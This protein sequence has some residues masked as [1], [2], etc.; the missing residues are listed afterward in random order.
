MIKK[1]ADK[2]RVY[3][4]LVAYVSNE[5]HHDDYNELMDYIEFAKKDVELDA[6]M[7]R[8]WDSQPVT[9]SFTDFES[10]MLYGNI[11]SDKRFQSPVK[12]KLPIYKSWYGIAASI[13]LMTLLGGMLFLYGDPSKVESFFSRNEV[14]YDIKPGTNKAIL[15]LADGTEVV[16][17]DVKD[18]SLAK[19]TGSNIIQASG[20]QLVYENTSKVAGK[21]MYN[22][23]ETP[24]GGQYQVI[25]PDG[26]KVWLNAASKLKYPVAFAG[27]EKRIVELSGEAYFEVAHNRKQPFIVK[28][29]KQSL[30]VLGTHFN[31]NSYADEAE[32]KTTL[33]EGSVKVSNLKSQK[34]ILLQPGQ[35]SCLRGDLLNAGKA[36]IETNMAWKDGHFIFKNEDLAGI[37]RKISRWYNVDIVYEGDVVNKHFVGS[38]S[39]FR[40]VSEV[41]RKFELTGSVHF[42]IEEGRITVM[43]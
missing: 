32:T 3:N 17:S 23:V 36:D 11:L 14:K 27:Q 19:S 33:L 10:K 40:N 28:T 18:D 16:L 1:N 21:L 22:A 39:R 31:I 13:V 2:S 42:K 20:G 38:M 4:L 8:V 29:E 35:E 25:L 37:M 15:T 12:K 24:R 43:Q 34:E 26:S 6:F 9:Q 30:E 5:I 7:K 41:L